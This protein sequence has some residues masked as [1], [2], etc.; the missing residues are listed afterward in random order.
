MDKI[1]NFFRVKGNEQSAQ[2][3]LDTGH[4]ISE[5]KSQEIQSPS[6]LLSQKP[7]SPKKAESTA[8]PQT[9]PSI[10][11]DPRGPSSSDMYLANWDPANLNDPLLDIDEYGTLDEISLKDSI[12]LDSDTAS[13]DKEIDSDNTEI[14]NQENVKLETN[15]SPS[16]PTTFSQGFVSRFCFCLTKI[17]PFFKNIDCI[18]DKADRVYAKR[19]ANNSKPIMKQ[20]TNITTDSKHRQRILDDLFTF[21][22]DPINILS[23]LTEEFQNMPV[24]KR[25][26]SGPNIADAFLSCVLKREYF[27][28]PSISNDSIKQAFEKCLDEAAKHSAYHNVRKFSIKTSDDGTPTIDVSSRSKKK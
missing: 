15:K 19:I 20:I 14:S 1:L 24:D 22:K 9:I 5:S 6:L 8:T 17:L 7:G 12:N 11:A 26:L 2:S 3:S 4:Q 10:N 25:Y 21:S 18:I 16:K 13:T 27:R 28:L 23:R